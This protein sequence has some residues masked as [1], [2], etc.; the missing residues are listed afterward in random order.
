M[1]KVCWSEKLS[2]SREISR[3]EWIVFFLELSRLLARLMT[4]QADIQENTL[5]LFWQ[6]GICSEHVEAS[7]ILS[8]LL[9]QTL[10][11]TMDVSVGM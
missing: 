1:D 10:K 6:L 3:S 2:S 5:H 4:S 9:F 7:Q 8:S 11:S